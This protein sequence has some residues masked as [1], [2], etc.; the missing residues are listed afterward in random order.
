MIGFDFDYYKPN[1][2]EEAQKAYKDL[3]SQGKVAIYY[4]GGTEIISKA[5]VNQ[6]HFDAII[7]I[8]GIPECSI[9][10]FK[11]DKLIIGAATT[12]TQI[13]D[14]AFFPLLSQSCRNTAD[15]TAR[16]KITIGGNICGKIIYKE[17]LLPLLLSDGEAVISDGEGV[18]SV[19]LTQIF[20]KE[21]QLEEGEFLI[22][23]TINKEY[24]F[25]PYINIKKTKQGK[26][27]Y[28][29]VT[30]ASIKKDNKIRIAFSG[31]CSYPFRLYEIEDNQNNINN[32]IKI[33]F[34]NIMDFLPSPIMEDILG[35][36]EYR[37]FVT[38]NTLDEALEKLGGVLC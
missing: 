30:V 11:E 31:L 16:D 15:H 17:P 14:S 7:D 27:D 8:K 28:P 23:I 3:K 10:G 34:N 29:L 38:R 2:I 9:Y 1:S 36:A 13:S 32:E 5:R 18:K 37:K 26:V 24:I 12:L 4:S 22:Q 25:L 6:I 19:P 21:L 33:E 20:D 35:T